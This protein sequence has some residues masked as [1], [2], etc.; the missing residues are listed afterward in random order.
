MK[1]EP[2][3]PPTGPRNRW[4]QSLRFPG[5]RPTGAWEVRYGAE[6]IGFVSIEGGRFLALTLKLRELGSFADRAEAAKAVVAWHED[7][8]ARWA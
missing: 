5:R 1:H 7:W 6:S 4:L 3:P 8:C 2:L